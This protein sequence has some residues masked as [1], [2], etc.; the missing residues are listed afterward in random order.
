MEQFTLSDRVDSTGSGFGFPLTWLAFTA[1]IAGVL[2]SIAVMGIRGTLTFEDF[3][4]HYPCVFLALTAI[5]IVTRRW[6]QMRMKYD[7]V[8][9]IRF[10][11]YLFGF[12][13]I[14]LT[15]VA[16]LAFSRS[17]DAIPQGTEEVL[18]Q[19]SVVSA[20]R[21]AVNLMWMASICLITC[22]SIHGRVTNNPCMTVSK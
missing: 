5:K 1:A 6:F 11:Y 16:A 20:V 9:H 15:V 18:S 21:T 17:R 13:A 8:R 3:P 22:L 10:T 4:W 12:L 7:N 14:A 19:D 2:E